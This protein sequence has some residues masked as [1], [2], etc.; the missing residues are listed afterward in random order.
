M[1]DELYPI[2]VLIEELKNENTQV[3]TPSLCDFSFP[4]RVSVGRKVGVVWCVH[5]RKGARGEQ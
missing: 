3:V 5:D 1:G 2:A 4:F